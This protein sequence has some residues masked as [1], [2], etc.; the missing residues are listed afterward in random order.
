MSYGKVIAV[1]ILTALGATV[2]GA[3]ECMK[4]GGIISAEES[5]E[6]YCFDC[7]FLVP[8][9]EPTQ[10][11]NGIAVYNFGRDV[12]GFDVAPIFAEEVAKTGK[13]E[14]KTLTGMS[15]LDLTNAFRAARCAQQQLVLVGAANKSDGLLCI[16]AEVFDIE[17]GHRVGFGNGDIKADSSSDNTAVEL[18]VR[19]FAVALARGLPYRGRYRRIEGKPTFFEFPSGLK[20]KRDGRV[21]IYSSYGYLSRKYTVGEG[22]EAVDKYCF[23]VTPVKPKVVITESDKLE[24]TPGREGKVGEIRITGEQFEDDDICYYYYPAEIPPIDRRASVGCA[25]S[26]TTHSYNYREDLKSRENAGSVSVT[27]TRRLKGSVLGLKLPLRWGI[28]A[29]FDTP[30]NYYYEYGGVYED[31]GRIMGVVVASGHV[32]I[33]WAV[34]GTK[35]WFGL[36]LGGEADYFFAPGHG[37]YELEDGGFE[38]YEN[39]LWRGLLLGLRGEWV[40]IYFGPRK[41]IGVA[42]SSSFSWPVLGD[43][44]EHFGP[45]WRVGSLGMRYYF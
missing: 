30:V 22:D 33:D 25:A 16:S 24:I 31:R 19:E 23:D 17:T 41:R 4:C 35:R 7:G 29:T 9:P 20:R 12:L 27:F 15:F 14:A 36:W 21:E 10:T 42:L 32:A 34:L 45:L 1:A 6:G 2:V 26:F 37:V 8:E 44:G 38:R 3:T 39:E 18:K 5:Q 28:G 13:F 11:W 43:Y 40:P